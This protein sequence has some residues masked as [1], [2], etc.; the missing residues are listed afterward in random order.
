MAE[1]TETLVLDGKKVAESFLVCLKSKISQL[2]ETTGRSP[3]LVV[4][5]VGEDPA[6]QV[7]VR[8]KTK[9][10]QELGLDSELLVLPTKTSQLE[11]INKVQALS[12]DQS[13]TGI[14]VQMPLPKHLDP[15]PVLLS[16]DPL[17]D[18]DGL[19]PF[20]LGMILTGK[21][22][23]VPCT[24]YGIM[25][26]LK[27]YR[28]DPAGKRALV[29]GR[30][31]LVGKPIAE[32]L[33]NADATVTIAH[34]KT[35]NLQGL[36]READILVAAA[37]QPEFIKADWIKAGAILIDVGI[38][39]NLEGKLVGDIDFAGCLGKAAAISPV[40]GGIG[41]LT[42]AHLMINTVKAFELQCFGESSITL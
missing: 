26:L 16:I 12:A 42:V 1:R 34:S 27:A 35:Q 21:P 30:S 28:I 22:C 7:Y 37:G 11:L 25:Q 24:P 10:A 15:D 31:R 8:N 19:H 6:S 17:K 29:I 3:K 33:L 36:C 41:P 5:L 14:L 4:V 20:N 13:I 23:L 38:N 18:V 32:L 39:R 9:K 2:K 40:P